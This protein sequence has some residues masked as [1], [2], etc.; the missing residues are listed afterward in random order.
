[1][2]ASRASR[3]L[4][5]L[6]RTMFGCSAHTKNVAYKS[7]VRPCLE[8]ACVVW[9]PHSAKD[10]ALLEAVQNRAARW[11]VKSHWDPAILKWT[12]SSN[13]CVL[14][15]HWPSLSSR[16]VF[17][18]CLFVFQIFHEQVISG[19]K[20]FFVLSSSNTRSHK[21]SFQTISSTI[22]FYR[23]SFVVNSI[24]CGI[25]FLYKWFPPVHFPLLK[26]HFIN[27]YFYDILV[28]YCECLFL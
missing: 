19:L 26:R 4:N 10:S 15:L 25:N 22:D 6:R 21:M 11:I 3:V 13:N 14:E 5:V 20:M 24:F 1:M 16:R 28:L 2:A 18:T 8:Y 17:L 9:S 7:I 12:K 23:H 27:S